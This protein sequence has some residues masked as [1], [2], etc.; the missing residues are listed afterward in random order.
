MTCLETHRPEQSP[1]I[2]RDHFLGDNTSQ[3][4]LKCTFWQ[5]THTMF[6]GNDMMPFKN[7]Q[8]K[9]TIFEGMSS[10]NYLKHYL[11]DVSGKNTGQLLL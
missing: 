8:Y 5:K 11:E 9:K 6:W 2:L 1:K 7:G 10:K 3:V 4:Y